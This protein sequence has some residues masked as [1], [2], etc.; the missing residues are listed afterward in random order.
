MPRKPRLLPEPGMIHVIGR[1]NN[2]LKIFRNK[3]DYNLFVRTVLRFIE[4][5][6]I[7]IQHYA[8]MNT[9]YHMLVWLEPN[10]KL[11]DFIKKLH[12]TYNYYYNK[13]YGRK[14]H[15]WHNRYR[16]ILVKNDIY[17]LQCARYIELNP[18]HAG[19]CCH[20][21]EYQWSSYNYYAN[22]KK[23]KL[24][25]PLINHPEFMITKLSHGRMNYEKYVMG[26][27]NHDYQKLKKEFESEK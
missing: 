14:G 7:Y 16:G 17:W 25:S 20:P 19:I 22:S 1:G 15:L 5:T 12:I 3:S 18:V 23:D 4:D 24:L 13:K 21:G 11:P 27:L 10:H 8:L 6:N 9:H 2:K 26:G